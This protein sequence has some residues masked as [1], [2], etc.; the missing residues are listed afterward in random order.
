MAT[1]KCKCNHCDSSYNKEDVKRLYGKDNPIY[2][3]GFCCR[4]CY[5]KHVNTLHIAPYIKK[6]K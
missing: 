2:L 6:I 5:V 4:T 1:E 3:N